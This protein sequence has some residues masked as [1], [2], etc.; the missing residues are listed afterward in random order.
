MTDKEDKN[1]SSSLLVEVYRSIPREILGIFIAVVGFVLFFLVVISLPHLFTAIPAY[2]KSFTGSPPGLQQC[3]EL[4]E[5]Q[6]AVYRFNRC[7][8]ETQRVELP[9]ASTPASLPAK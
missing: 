1:G 3:W 7:T 4:K 6:A 8:G 5:V 2:I 9:T